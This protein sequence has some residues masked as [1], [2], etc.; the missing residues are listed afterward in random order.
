MVGEKKQFVLYIDDSGSRFPDKHDME[1]RN[2]GMDHFALGGILIAVEDKKALQEAYISFCKKWNID[3]PLHST[4]IRGMRNNFSWLE[5]GAKKD[6]FYSELDSFLISL[7]VIGF[8]AVI[9]RPGYN[10]RYNEKYEG[11]PWWMCKTVYAILIE[12]VAKYVAEQSGILI[13]RFER[14]GKREDRAIIQYARDLKVRGMP[15]NIDT[16]K[17]YDILQPEDFRSVILG[18]PRRKLKEN[19]FVQIADL[20]LYPMAKRKYDPM[21]NPWVLLYKNKKVIDALVSEREWSSKGIKY[22]CFDDSGSKKP[23]FP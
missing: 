21:Y 8:A 15:F 6:V 19:L 17:K 9:H 20:Y 18:E 23:R 11:K 1:C 5:G 14:T 7:P 10:E 4:K 12:R 2:D 13:V 16:S 22:S 3:Y